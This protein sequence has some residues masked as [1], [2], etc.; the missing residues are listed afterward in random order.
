MP[1]LIPTLEDDPCGRLTALRAIYD[2]LITGRSVV[3]AEFKGANGAGRR[4]KYSSADVALLKSEIDAAA[5]ACAGGGDLPR[6]F[7]IGGRM[8]A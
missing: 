5:T 7:A 1:A 6:R 3:E 2:A 4:T 8:N